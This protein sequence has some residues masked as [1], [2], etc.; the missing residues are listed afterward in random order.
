MFFG[1]RTKRRLGLAFM[2][3]I[4]TTLLAHAESTQDDQLFIHVTANDGNSDESSFQVGIKGERKTSPDEWFY[5]ADFSYGESD[6]EKNVENAGSSIQYNWL[7][8]ERAYVH[9]KAEASYDAI[10]DVDYRFIAGP[11]GIGFY[12]LSNE[13]SSIATE[14]AFAYLW[15]KVGGVSRDAPTIRLTQRVTHKLSEK[16]KVWASVDYLP[17]ADEFGNYLLVSEAG[18]EAM[19]NGRVSLRFTVKDTYDSEPADG[20]KDN[21]IAFFTGIGLK[22]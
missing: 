4:A 3:I 1:S 19:M 8:G 9:M 11:P 14:L 21:D 15:E 16:S 2:A 5:G 10:A 12:L 22:L 17:E 20:K 7:F 18:L 13:E 6:G